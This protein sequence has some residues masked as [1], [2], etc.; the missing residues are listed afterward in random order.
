MLWAEFNECE[1]NLYLVRVS[2]GWELFDEEGA[3]T[4]GNVHPIYECTDLPI[5]SSVLDWVD[6]PFLSF[7]TMEQN[8]QIL[9]IES[10]TNATA[11]EHY[12]AD[13][14]MQDVRVLTMLSTFLLEIA[15]RP[16]GFE[17][18]PSYRKCM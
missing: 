15:V 4:G 11:F 9:P 7:P 5:I 14:L 3:R 16:I 2:L 6:F 1:C 18:C 13:Y 17:K 10:L 12:T 8:F